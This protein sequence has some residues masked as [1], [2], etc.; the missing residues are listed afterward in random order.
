[1][2]PDYEK[3]FNHLGYL[4]YSVGVADE[5][6]GPAEVQ[7]LKELISC[8]WVPQEGT[9]G[10][11]ANDAAHHII[12]VFDRLLEQQTPAEEAFCAFVDF[13][14]GNPAA[15]SSAIKHRISETAGTVAHAFGTSFENDEHYLFRLHELLTDDELVKQVHG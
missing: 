6:V 9:V 3:I 7:R 11:H 12:Y 13:Y 10:D 8:Y 2:I 1:M 5:S 15:F 4:F 14:S